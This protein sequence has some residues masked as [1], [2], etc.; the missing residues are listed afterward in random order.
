MPRII[1]ILFYFLD[2]EVIKVLV[3]QESERRSMAFI[4]NEADKSEQSPMNASC[5]LEVNENSKKESF[6]WSDQ[7]V[8]LFLEIYRNKEPEFNSGLKR[9]N[10]IWLDIAN[11]MKEAKY[12]VTATQCQNK[13]SGLRRTYKNI[14]DNNKKSGNHA[15]S[16]AFYST[17]D[18]IFGGKAWVE[19]VSIAS[20]DPPSPGSSLLEKSLSNKSTDGIA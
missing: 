18:S 19:P 6:I 14:S 17:M 7:A 5:A 10:K 8:L 11:E 15:S 20:S 9:H 2:E 3:D 4:N 12:D 13:M 1:K 16:W